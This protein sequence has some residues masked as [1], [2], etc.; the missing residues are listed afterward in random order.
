MGLWNFLNSD[1][2][3]DYSQLDVSISYQD[4]NSTANIIIKTSEG[5]DVSD[6]FGGGEFITNGS[7][8]TSRIIHTSYNQMGWL[9]GTHD[10]FSII[11]DDGHISEELVIDVVGTSYTNNSTASSATASSATAIT[12]TPTQG[13]GTTGCEETSQGCYLPS[14]ATVN[15]G[16]TVIFSNT[17]TTVHTWSEGTTG[18]PTLVFDTS[19]VMPGASYEYIPD[20][21]GEFSYFCMVHPWMTGVLIV[22]EAGYVGTVGE[23]VVTLFHNATSSTDNTIYISPNALTTECT[24]S[25]TCIIPNN[26]LVAVNQNVTWS[27][28]SF[29][30][31]IINGTPANG[32]DG[33]FDF[34]MK[35]NEVSVFSF[36]QPGTYYYFD[37]L[38]PWIKGSVTVTEEE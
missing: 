8:T 33:L 18:D 7:G 19:M 21:V 24:E 38:H 16:G 34:G 1:P 27:A 3:L 4:L 12:I 11:V 9:D 22:Q 35:I 6:T 26:L 2:E 30:T 14:V 15:L 25:A 20:T 32:P 13:S 36:N 28:T 23:G 5:L 37:M 10:S 17:D 31:S 29:P